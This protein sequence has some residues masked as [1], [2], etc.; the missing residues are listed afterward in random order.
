MQ[1][2]IGDVKPDSVTLVFSVYVTF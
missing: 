1:V 2:I